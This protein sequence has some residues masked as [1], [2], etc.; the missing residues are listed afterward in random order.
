MLKR[1]ALLIKLQKSRFF[2]PTGRL[3]KR[4]WA[5]RRW[6]DAAPIVPIYFNT[7]VYLLHPSVK[8]WQP[9]PMDHSDYRYV[10]LDPR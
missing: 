9:T 6:N 4:R 10:W 3:R 8:G 1:N 2:R 5:L 7:H